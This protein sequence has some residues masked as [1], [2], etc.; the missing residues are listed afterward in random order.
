MDDLFK[1]HPRPWVWG[2]YDSHDDFIRDA[3]GDALV[4][5]GFNSSRREEIAKL[6]V[7]LVNE[8]K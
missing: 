8:V 3:N 5:V 2:F 4:Q 7:K 6:I 1:K